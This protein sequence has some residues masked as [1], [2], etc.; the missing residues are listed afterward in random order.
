[1]REFV[2][3]MLSKRIVFLDDEVFKG[4]PFA[5]SITYLMFKHILSLQKLSNSRIPLCLANKILNGPNNSFL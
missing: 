3:S 1:M 4:P 5:S 2:N